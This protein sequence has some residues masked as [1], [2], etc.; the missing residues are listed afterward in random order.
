MC[1]DRYVFVR[2]DFNCINPLI[3]RT[4]VKRLRP[5]LRHA[6]VRLRAHK[7]HNWF[8]LP[9]VPR[10]HPKCLSTNTFACKSRSLNFILLLVTCDDDGGD[11]AG[12]PR[13]A[14]VEWKCHS[15][16]LIRKSSVKAVGWR[17]RTCDGRLWGF[18]VLLVF[19]WC[20]NWVR[21]KFLVEKTKLWCSMQQWLVRWTCCF[22]NQAR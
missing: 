7:S 8:S 14:N 13:R 16:I 20:V 12:D 15:H 22:A 10:H 4:H 19:A 17:I 3:F 9:N 21:T 11:T 6:C 5:L 18:F 2:W 1:C